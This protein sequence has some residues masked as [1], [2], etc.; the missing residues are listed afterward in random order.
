MIRLYRAPTSQLRDYNRTRERTYSKSGNFQ[1]DA[2]DLMTLEQ[3][4]T[5]S[6]MTDYQ[7]KLL[8]MYYV[9]EY[10]QPEIAL[11][12]N[13]SQATVSITIKRAENHLHNV[14][15]NWERMELNEYTCT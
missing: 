12:V 15:K 9:E 7:R 1:N 14:F 11:I 2:D 10:S 13:K 6:E 4:L 5:E 8:R 3:A